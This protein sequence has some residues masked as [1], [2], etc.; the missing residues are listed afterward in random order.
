MSAHFKYRTTLFSHLFVTQFTHQGAPLTV[1][2]KHSQFSTENSIV[3]GDQLYQSH[4]ET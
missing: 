4:E 1:A 3:L 2:F